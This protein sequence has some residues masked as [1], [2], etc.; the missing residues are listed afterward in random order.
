MVIYDICIIKSISFIVS[1]RTT[2]LNKIGPKKVNR[3][4]W[5][6]DKLIRCE[7]SLSGWVDVDKMPNTMLL[8][9]STQLLNAPWNQSCVSD[10]RNHTHTHTH[11]PAVIYAFLQWHSLRY[12]H[13]HTAE[14]I[15]LIRTRLRHFPSSSPMHTLLCS[16]Q[17]YQKTRRRG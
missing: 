13:V 10:F 17:N 5:N 16:L 11:T 4:W 15:A 7:R 1:F 12:M 14:C 6:R 9:W 2:S 8:M 3:V